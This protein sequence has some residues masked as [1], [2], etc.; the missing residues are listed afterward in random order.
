MFRLPFKLLQAAL[1]ALGDSN[2][3]RHDI[4]KVRAS[5]AFSIGRI[6]HDDG[7]LFCIGVRWSIYIGIDLCEKHRRRVSASKPNVIHTGTSSFD[8]TDLDTIAHDDFD[9]LLENNVEL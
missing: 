5:T 3:I 2:S 4:H 6:G 9:I 8:H 7:D 1:T